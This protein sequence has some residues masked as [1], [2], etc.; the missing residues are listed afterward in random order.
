MADCNDL[1]D[2][3][4]VAIKL[5]TKRDSLKTS[6]AMQFVKNTYSLQSLLKLM[7]PNSTAGN[8]YMMRT[9]VN[10]SRQGI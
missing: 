2:K 4:H 5:T 1:F 3:Y 6:R 8:S 9:T 7:F 10:P